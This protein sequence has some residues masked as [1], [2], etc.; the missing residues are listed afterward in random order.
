MRQGKYEI[1]K[2]L[3]KFNLIFISA[4]LILNIAI[5]IF[6]FAGYLTPKTA[7][8]RQAQNELLYDYV[9]NRERFDRGYAD[10]RIRYDKHRMLLMQAVLSDEPFVVE[11]IVFPNEII[12]LESYGDIRLYRDV[13][14]I[15]NRAE[16]FNRNIN[17][18]LREAHSRIREMGI[19][20]RGQFVYEYQL[21]LI[22]H[23]REVADLNIRV[24][25]QY[26]WSEFFTLQTPVI[27][28]IITFL[29]VFTNI[30][31]VERRT[32]IIN[33]L[34]ICKNGGNK[35]GCLYLTVQT[36]FVRP[37]R[38][39]PLTSVSLKKLNCG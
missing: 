13:R 19:E 36:L 38:L 3:N 10:F 8:I 32:K 12:D 1:L 31:I 15:I 7:I 23:Y 16:N 35:W 39:P 6:Q 30:F 17:N 27:F 37:V 5:V 29:G 33:I 28:L 11:N 26:G 34:N 4:M 18:V 2:H 20:A 14:A 24:E 22:L 9:N 21:A 25:N